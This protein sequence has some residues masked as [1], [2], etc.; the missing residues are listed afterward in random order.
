MQKGTALIVGVTGVSGHNLANVLVADGWT[1]YGLARNPTSQTGVIPVKA[2][3]LE[4]EATTQA[5]KGLAIT[6]VFFCTWTRRANEAE[7]VA[8]NGAM[9][10]N[11]CESLREAPLAHMALVT[12]TKHYLGSFENYGSGKAETPFRESEPRQPGENFYYTLEDILFDAASEY[13]FSWSVHRSHTMIGRALGSNAMNMGV[14]LAVYASLCKETGQPF[15]FPGS[16]TQWDSLTDL[17]DAGLLGRQ[18]AWAAQAPA[19]RNQAFNTVNGDVFRWRWMWGEI[20]AFFDVPAAPFPD[21]PMP[22]EARFKD[23]APALW[24]TLAA[25][26]GLVESDVN[27]LASWWHTDADLGREIECLNDMTKSRDAGFMGYYD[28]RASFLELFTALRAQ[29]VIP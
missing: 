1:V 11:L 9:M 15:V 24:A 2:D 25:K 18:L 10:R 17:T 19:A 22:L 5:L 28:S 14:T 26:H 3:L 7:N 20:A 6:H 23:A 27:K 16:R 29:R 21:A 4:P 12:G 8:A 13:D